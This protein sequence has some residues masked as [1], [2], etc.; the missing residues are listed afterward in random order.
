M[1]HDT[2]QERTRAFLYG[3]SVFTT[4]RVENGRIYFADAHQKRLLES[5]EW[6]WP[7]TASQAE[8]LWNSLTPPGDK[9]TWRITLTAQATSRQLRLVEPAE[10]LLDDWWTP[11]LPPPQN[12]KARTV[13]AAARPSEWP[14]YLKT[15]DYLA[16]LVA[17]RKV[18]VDEIPL[19]HVKEK[20]CEFLHANVFFWDGRGFHTPSVG[21]D[22]L[23]GLGRA[24]FVQMLQSAK[25]PLSERE[26]S[27]DELPTF[28]ST[29]AANAVRGLISV[30][31][32]DGREALRHPLLE[33]WQRI[34]FENS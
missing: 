24:R 5:A 3:E 6:L 8:R 22:V 30:D 4:M 25:I 33:T 29:L 26:I 10:L 17:A 32:I 18:A 19:F 11:E 34:F 31:M 23:A 9:G 20:I 2:R 27:L 15:G 13:R 14:A 16:R 28:K 12:W 7:G 21:P 1:G